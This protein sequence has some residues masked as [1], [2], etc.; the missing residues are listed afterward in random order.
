MKFENSS[1]ILNDIISFQIYPLYKVGTGY[2][3]KKKV[4]E[5]GE[6]CKLPENEDE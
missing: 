1:M 5:E 6:S 4:I 2:E 3:N